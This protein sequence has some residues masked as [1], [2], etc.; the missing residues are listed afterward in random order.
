MIMAIAK[1][2]ILI[3]KMSII[4][5]TLTFFKA[6]VGMFPWTRINFK[7]IVKACELRDNWWSNVD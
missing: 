7:E 6:F 1:N 3:V 2:P 4:V 5:F